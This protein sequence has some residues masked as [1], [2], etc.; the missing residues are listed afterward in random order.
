MQAV[1]V[2][3]PRRRRVPSRRRR[4][5]SSAAS[6]GSSG[7]EGAVSVA[8]DVLRRRA[9]SLA[10]TVARAGPRAG[11]IAMERYLPSATGWP[12]GR[13]E[14]RLRRYPAVRVRVREI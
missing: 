8:V 9:A 5:S 4:S 11:R 3:E 14:R 10:P 2:A 6:G 7:G 1:R 12:A 13:R